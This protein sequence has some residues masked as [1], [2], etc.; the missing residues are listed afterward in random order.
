MCSKLSRKVA[1]SGNR[2]PM[3]SAVLHRDK[4]QPHHN[5]PVTFDGVACC[6]YVDESGDGETAVV[7]IPEVEHDGEQRPV[8]VLRLPAERQREILEQLI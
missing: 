8:D 5:E 2:L 7:L 4:W 3:H 1:R 6:I